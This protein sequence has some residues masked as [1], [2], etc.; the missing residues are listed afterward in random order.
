MEE[1]DRGGLCF[2]D[3]WY[4]VLPLPCDMGVNVIMCLLS[5]SKGD[6]HLSFWASM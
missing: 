3:Q 1:Q 6:W 5:E 4:V 2:L